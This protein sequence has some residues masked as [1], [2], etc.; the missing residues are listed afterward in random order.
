MLL[1]RGEFMWTDA[2]R[3]ELIRDVERRPD[4]WSTGIDNF[5]NM[6]DSVAREIARNLRTVATGVDTPKSKLCSS[7]PFRYNFGR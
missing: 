6:V 5:N 4:I 1:K 7:S 3:L 2:L